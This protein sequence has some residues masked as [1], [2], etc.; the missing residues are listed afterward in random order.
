MAEI[1]EMVYNSNAI[2]NSTLTL[3]DTEDILLRDQI[4]RDHDV[5]EIYEA[6]NLAK[7]TEYL[8]DN[9]N[10]KLSI[11]LIL[12]LHKTLLTD[13]NNNFAGRFR[14][15]NEWVRVG[16]HIGA[17]P[18]FVAGLMKG[19]VDKYNSK[20]DE[21]FL[22]RIAY[23]HAELETVH[24]F[25]DGN[26]RMGRVLINQ[27][28]QALKLPPIIIRNKNKH[29]DYYPLF[30]KYILTTKYDGFTSLFASLLTEALYRRITLLNA[31]KIIPLTKWA[32]NNGVAGNAA[33]NK[34]LRQTIPAFRL[35]ERWMIAAD[36]QV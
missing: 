19:L 23:F 26:G 9:L 30:D 14:N 32:M 31:P 28:L 1:P 18:D 6:K 25:G 35:R 27:Q 12:S 20:D 34:A 24:P 22:N 15:H 21:Y 13:I 33:N 11:D 4:K 29:T 7:I 3:E 10:A 2:E 8:L 16:T 17:N 36:Y 5:R